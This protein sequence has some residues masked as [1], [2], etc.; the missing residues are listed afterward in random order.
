MPVPVLDL[1][2]VEHQVLLGE[3]LDDV[4]GDGLDLLACEGRELVGVPSGLGDGAERCDPVPLPSLVIVGTVAGGG[5]DQS[6]VV[7][8]DVVGGDDG[9]CAVAPG[10]GLHLERR[11][12]G[13]AFQVFAPHPLEDLEPLVSSLLHDVL[14]LSL[15]G[16]DCLLALVSGELHAGVVHV[17]V[18]GHG[19]VGSEG[20]GG[21]GPDEER[22]GAVFQGEP[23]HDRGVC[24]VPVL[25]LGLGESGLAPGAPGDDPAGGTEEL[26]L[27]G[28]LDGPPCGLE[29]IELD[30]LIGVVPIHPHPELLELLGHVL[31][32]AQGE[33]PAGVD[34]LVYP[35]RLDV[36]L[37]VDADVLLDLDLDREAVHIE[38]GLVADVVS[39]HP[40]VSDQ[41]VLDGLVHGRAQVD[42]PSGVRGAV[43]EVEPLP[44]LAELLRL[45]IGVGLS[46]V[47]LD[48]L[49]DA[50]RIIIGADLL[51]HR[52]PSNPPGF[53]FPR[54]GFEGPS[55][56]L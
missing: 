4:V 2:D 40:P 23:D 41:D 16:D 43:D 15:E 45:V 9:P 56:Y 13:E 31:V 50:L 36:L 26:L 3:H 24:L 53:F 48:I 11:D 6:G 49:L 14:G 33:L 17:G 10:S 1:A 22:C 38:S 37:G 54:V 34:E 44:V 5:V 55:R 30:G 39:A 42:G 46:P 12:I 27:L 8:L 52:I 35:E 19:H 21:G 25:D 20:P 32:E 28:P 51:Y 47:L 7:V 18:G 29:V